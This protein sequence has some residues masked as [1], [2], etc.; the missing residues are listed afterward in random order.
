VSFP[1]DLYSAAM[2]DS[3]HVVPL[4]CHEYAVPKATSQGHG[5]VVAGKL[6]GM[7]ELASAVL[8]R[9][10][11]DL[12]AFGFFRQPR[13]VIGRLT[14]EAFESQAQVASVKQT[15]VCHGQGEAYDFGERT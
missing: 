15:N 7:C 5:K 1:F 12:P 10:V 3:Y 6:H 14:S 2:F 11:G 9:H 8:R 13:G 4:P